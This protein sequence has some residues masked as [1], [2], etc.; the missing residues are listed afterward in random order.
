M[1]SKL[2][3]NSNIKLSNN[4]MSYI[5]HNNEIGQHANNCEI[6]QLYDLLKISNEL[7][8]LFKS[9]TNTPGLN[10]T[11]PMSTQLSK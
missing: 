3:I 7:N 11:V 1:K 6:F 2:T 9:N 10:G 4:G 8:E 5:T